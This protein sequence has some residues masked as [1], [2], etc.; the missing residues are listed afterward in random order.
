MVPCFECDGFGRVEVDSPMPHA[1][2]F[3]CG[4]MGSE[5]IACEACGGA[6]ELESLC[7]C[8][9]PVGDCEECVDG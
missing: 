1:G 2:G 5:V 7:P 4:Y 6:G 8:G 3:N 9:H